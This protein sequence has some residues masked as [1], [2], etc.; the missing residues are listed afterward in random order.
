MKAHLVGDPEQ[1]AE[2]TRWC[3]WAGIKLVDHP[4]Q[5]D[6]LII[7]FTG[8]DQIIIAH[9]PKYHTDW[10]N[11]RAALAQLATTELI[12]GKKPT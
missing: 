3:A 7:A 2:T 1:H 10:R 11:A 4:D 6:V 12:S 8:D 5:A 9:R